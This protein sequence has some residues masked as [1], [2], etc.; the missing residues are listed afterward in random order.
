MSDK[1]TAAQENAAQQENA[2]ARPRVVMSPPQNLPTLYTNAF[3]TTFQP[4]EFLIAACVSHQDSDQNG[5]FIK[6]QQQVILGMTA[7]S[8]KRLA[9]AMVQ[10]VKQYEQQH[11][12]IAL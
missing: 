10:V 11:G 8:A 3:Q 5:P 9:L 4:G 7:E 2:Q 12:E 1:Q 6:V